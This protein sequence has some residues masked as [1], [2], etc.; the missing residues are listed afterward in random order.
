MGKKNRLSVTLS[1]STWDFL[2]EEAARQGS[3][4][5][6]MAHQFIQEGVESAAIVRDGRPEGAS[7]THQSPRSWHR[8]WDEEPARR[9]SSS[10]PR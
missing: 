7:L 10:S 2:L 9:C 1:D 3:S 8:V 6:A 5:S 4:L